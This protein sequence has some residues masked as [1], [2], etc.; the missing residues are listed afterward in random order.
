MASSARRT[1]GG[2]MLVTS[3]EK[4]PPW[5]GTVVRAWA[6]IE[7]SRSVTPAAFASDVTTPETLEAGDE[8][9]AVLAAPQALSAR[10]AIMRAAVLRFALGR[11]HS[12]FRWSLEPLSHV[13]AST[14]HGTD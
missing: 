8:E 1:N 13:Y 9:P 4:A 10:P 14:V 12:P 3:T 7:E 6:G 2:V 11:I 5:S